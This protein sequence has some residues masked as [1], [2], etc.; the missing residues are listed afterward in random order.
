M[1]EYD[2]A[3]DRQRLIA[4]KIMRTRLFF[5]SYTPLW[6]IFAIR[7]HGTVSQVVFWLLTGWGFLDTFRLIEA[8]LRRSTRH[9]RFDDISDRSG[10]VSGYLATYLLPFL[11]G[12][13]L[14]LRGWFAYGVYFLVAWA[15]F[16]PSELGL[17]NPMLYILGWR[18]VEGTRR[19]RSEL[20]ICQDPPGRDPEGEPVA[21]LMGGAGWIH[22]PTRRPWTWVSRR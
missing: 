1:S 14:D 11:G 15:V 13:P 21:R 22:R 3:W 17:V 9:V 16:V 7:S 12:P 20:I 8:G 10:S 18:L 19:G 2:T 6:A 5:I 4:Q